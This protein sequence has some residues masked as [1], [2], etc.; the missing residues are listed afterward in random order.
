MNCN[1]PDLQNPV[2]VVDDADSNEVGKLLADDG[3]LNNFSGY[4]SS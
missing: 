1:Y 2:K 3:I 4:T